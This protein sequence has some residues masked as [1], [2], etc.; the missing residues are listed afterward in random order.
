MH[1]ITQAFLVLVFFFKFDPKLILYTWAIHQ[2]FDIPKVVRE[3]MLKQIFNL[4]HLI[5]V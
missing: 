1:V 5:G 3:C 4:N 2:F